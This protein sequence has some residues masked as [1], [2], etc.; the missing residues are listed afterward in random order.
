MRSR[1]TIAALLLTFVVLTLSAT[2]QEI[3][4]S[5]VGTIKDSTG[6][7]VPGTTV[8]VL[9]MDKNVVI[10]TV[11]ANGS[12]EYVAPLLPIGNY[13]ITATAPGFKRVTQT[14]VVL[15]VSDKLT[16]NLAL[17]VGSAE[18]EVT[19]QADALQVEQQSATAAGLISGTQVRELSL[20]SR[21]YEQ[22]VALQPG[23]SYGGGDQLYMGVMNPNGESNEVNFSINGGRDNANNWTIDGADNVDRG[24]NTT[25]LN[26]PSVDSIAEFKVLRGMYNAEYGRSAGGQINVITKSGERNFH[27]SAYEFFRNDVLNANTFFNNHE[28]IAK[29]PLRYNNF[30]WTLGG[31]VY[32]PG[33][34][35]TGRNKTF[36]F[37]SQEFRR[38]ITSATSSPGIVPTADEKNGIFAD[39]ICIGFDAMGNCT[40][41]GNQIPK[42]I[43][44]PGEMQSQTGQCWDPGAFAYV[45]DWFDKIANPQDSVTHELIS[46]MRNVF[47]YR[48]E[49]FKI[50]HVF[51]SK[52]NAS[53]R[54]MN[55]S[56]PT[57]DPTG[58][59]TG[60]N[61]PGVAT[62]STNSPGRNIMARV[63]ATFSP[64]FLLEAGYA[65]SYGA[66]VSRNIG[67]ASA[68][69]SPDVVSAIA[70][71]YPVTLGRVPVLSFDSG[72]Y[73]GGFGNYDDFNR[74]HNWFG[75]LTKIVGKHTIKWGAI[76]NKYNKN[77]NAGGNNSGEFGFS[78]EGMVGHVGFEQAWANFLIGRAS[79]F[80]QNSID[81]VA[82][83][84]QNQLEL[85]LQDEWRLRP[86]L[87]LSY[88]VR[89][90]LY[91]QPTESRGWLTNF[92]PNLYDRAK[93][94]E[95]D[96]ETGLIISG[97][98]PDYDPLNGI[99]IGGKFA[100][101]GHASP[102]GSAVA[103]QSNKNI[104]PRIGIAWD[105][106]GKGKTSVRSGY[107]IFYD[108]PT[109][110]FV[111]DNAWFNPPLVSSITIN[112]ARLSDPACKNAPAVPCMGQPDLSVAPPNLRIVSTDWHLP[113]S[114]QWSLDI[115][116]ELMPALVIDIGYYGNKGTHL[117]GG[118][119]FNQVMPGVALANNV[120]GPNSPITGYDENDNP[121][122]PN[123]YGI[124]V[125]DYAQ[126]NWLRPYKGYGY[127]NAVMPWFKSSYHS[128]QVS[129]EKKFK[130]NSLLN[131][132]YTWSKNMTNSPGDRWV[133]PQSSYDISNDYGPAL[134][135]R[136]HMLTA[137]FVYE[138]PFMKTQQGFA[139]KLLGGWELSGIITY[140]SG[141]PMTVSSGSSIDHSGQGILQADW[142]QWSASYPDMT[143]NP[144]N[145]AK[146]FDQWFNTGV[147][148]EVPDGEY[149]VGTERRGS[150]RRPGFGRWD[151]SLFKNLKL[152]ERFNLQFRT[153]AFNVWNHTNFST[154]GGTLGADDFGRVTS[155]R[156]PRNVQFGLKL[157]F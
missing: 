79:Y 24:S 138:L 12:G 7:V 6:A 16:I 95:I 64:S 132:A 114:Q 38:I 57:E 154:V 139:G 143:G 15:N 62:T 153:E 129:V 45:Q 103:T 136:T 137:S 28:G 4:G 112:G 156:D 134:Y 74:N 111:E 108:S 100:D 106:F 115:Q 81:Q 72:E 14:N 131:V 98:N 113:Y 49:M 82:D 46:P 141:V 78:S 61:V 96:H 60:L 55:D 39:T 75:N 58:L 35:N 99:I 53:F 71:P 116:H 2:A 144:N 54:F 157:L 123:L 67:L 48:Q 63:T 80:A 76:F 147:F 92:D 65:Y 43:C 25:L 86:N 91:R 120:I 104:A 119:N 66:I 69:N 68:K 142:N 34:Y 125:D 101:Q 88:G 11:K 26:Y 150:V 152:S 59:W 27:G 97:G 51:N 20:N 52:L 149:R 31:P 44:Q 70:L 109:V 118:I 93:A 89:Y 127:I 23:V 18:I 121:I 85:F 56:I 135:D 122:Q 37:F 10:R 9:N 90:S 22:L 41:T 29:P 110:G 42:V 94:P 1:F 47:N 155:A 36:F 128:L 3:T 32:L 5:I 146:S 107:G 124:S 87:T 40:G 30:G 133:A 148:Q 117:L 151:M 126:L 21:N 8:S 73:W 50:D 145:G 130:G 17:E 102:W 19:V 33:K 84:H 105:P 77:E 140:N 83:I 13:S